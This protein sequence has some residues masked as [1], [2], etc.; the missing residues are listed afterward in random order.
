MSYVYG[1]NSFDIFINNSLNASFGL[2]SPTSADT[3]GLEYGEH[4]LGFD[5][6]GMVG[7]LDV[8]AGLEW[9]RESYE[10]RAGKLLSYIHCRQLPGNSETC[11]N[12]K[13]GWIQ[14]FSRLSPG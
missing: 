9:K 7:N 10:I 5:T 11:K 8:A 12:S 2:N 1:E 4:L 13:S 6:M 3:G 14:V